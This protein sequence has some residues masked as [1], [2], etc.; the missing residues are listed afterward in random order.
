MQRKHS[1]KY[2]AAH[3][4]PPPSMLS[5]ATFNTTETPK[6]RSHMPYEKAGKK[7]TRS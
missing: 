3:F 2:R 6:L 5:N 7:H 4:A 1:K